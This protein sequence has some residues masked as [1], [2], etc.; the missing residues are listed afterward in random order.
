M[1]RLLSP[2]L[3]PSLMLLGSFIV[4]ATEYLLAS[5]PFQTDI[6]C[7]ATWI[8]FKNRLEQNFSSVEIIEGLTNLL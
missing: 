3:S 5:C 4:R 2:A 6:L 8:D 1:E 7:H